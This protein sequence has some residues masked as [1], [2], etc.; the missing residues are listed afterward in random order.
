[1]GI[2]PYNQIVIPLLAFV[3]IVAGKQSDDSPEQALAR[4]RT[5][6]EALQVKKQ[7]EL[8]ARHLKSVLALSEEE[9]LR[10]RFTESADQ[11]KEVLGY[12][13]AI[14]SGLK[15]DGDKAETYLETGRRALTMARLSRTDGSLQYYTI[16]LPPHWDPAKPYPLIVGLHGAGPRIPLAYVN[17]TFTPH[18]KDEK[19]PR[20]VITIVPWGR[21][22]RG[23]REDSEADI[24]EAINDAKTFAK[25][26]PNR[27]Y[28]SG[29]SMGADGVWALV[30]R[31]PDL[32]A[33]AGM[34]AG[35]TYSAPPSLGLVQNAA[36]V[37]FYI[38]IGDQDQN[39][40]R[41]P[42]SQEARDALTAVGNVPKFVLQAGVGHSPRG[43]DGD[44]QTDWLLTHVRQRPSHFVYVVDS[45]THRGVWGILSPRPGR[46]GSP[47]PDGRVRIECTIEGS[48]VRIKA[49]GTQHLLIDLGAA[50]LQMS[51]NIEVFVNEKS[52]FQGAV[53]EKPIDVTW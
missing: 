22:N 18:A 9:V 4:I 53:P 43:E 12:L 38:W 23:W 15:D 14:D 39:R 1:M 48:N 33:A 24:W 16:G 26:D 44:A 41:I 45:P 50:G 52:V 28:I 30:Q 10:L 2:S 34:M 40:D 49:E 46:R 36:S 35:A 8:Y 13:Q 29:H 25:F 21:G 5:Q 11:A 7:P 37:P 27:W 31:T 42:S 32:W 20:D 17:F 47:V 19:P 51:G 3:G 6:I